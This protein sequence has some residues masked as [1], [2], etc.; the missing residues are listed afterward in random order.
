MVMAAF[1]WG[2]CDDSKTNASLDAGGDLVEGIVFEGER[3]GYPWVRIPALL[4]TPTGTLLAFAEGRE[5]LEDVGDI[6]LI[7]RRSE[8]QGE[9][10][11]GVIVVADV[12][13]DTAGNPAPVVDRDTGRIWLP[14]CTNPG[15]N[16][17]ERKVWVTW[18]DDDGLTWAEPVDISAQVKPDKWKW[19]ATGPGRS[20]QLTSG[21]I[22]VPS[23]HADENGV[24]RSHVFFSDDHGLSWTLGGSADPGT[25]E[26][27]VVELSDQSLLMNSRFQ[28]EGFV[29]AF[30]RSTDGGETWEKTKLRQDLPD[31]QCQGSMIMTAEGVL[32]SNPATKQKFPRDH[33]TIRLSDD[34]GENWSLSREIDSGPSAYSSLGYLGNGR[35]ALIWESGDVIPYDRVRF[36]AFSK[37]WLEK[38]E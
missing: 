20:I 33:M 10:W 37:E 38:T 32:M 5:S 1:L 22:V 4:E 9:S 31:P 8:D 28:G 13:A 14:Y 17:Y 2:G 26:S 16:A 35:F 34:E 6:D 25:D 24:R 15:D 27:Q 19:Y 23:N 21:R 29:R 3:E 30:S 12:G 7:L 11:G 18:S 36:A